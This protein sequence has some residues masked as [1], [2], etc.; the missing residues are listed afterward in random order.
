MSGLCIGILL[1]IGFGCTTGYKIP[2]P[3]VELLETGFSVSIPDEEG[4][5]VVAFNVNRN[6]NFTSFINEGQYNVRLTEPQNGRW[7]TN[8]SSVPLRAQDVLY[9]W[10]SVQHQKAVY[11]DL[12]QPLPVC[13]L[14]GE[15]RPKGCSP[16]DDDFT[17][18]NQLST[19]GSALEPTAPSVCEP[20]ETQVS[21]QIG[22]SICKGQLL[23][24][25][26]FDQLNESLWIHDVRLPLDS[27]DA[28]FVLYDGKAKVHDGNLVIEPLLW[29]SY[30]PDLSIA[31]SRLDLSE[32]CTGT[33]NRNKEC[34]LHSTGSGPSGIMPPIVT[35]RVSTKDTFAF[36]YG[37]IEMRAK[38]PKGDWIVPLLLLEPLTEWYGQSGYESGQLRVALARGNSVLR[39]PRGKLVDGR[40]LYG[41]PVL[42]T[43]AHQR[44]DLWLSKRKISH[45][46]DDFHTYSLDWSSNRLLFSVD[47]QVY[48][49]MLNGFTE[50]DENPRWKQGGPMAPFDKMFYISLG[51]SVG[52]FGDFVDHLR[53]ATYEKPWANYHP[54]AKLQ[55]HQAQDQWLPTW[56]QPA[57]KIDY[58]RVFAN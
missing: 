30:R 11:Q 50:L 6:R 58:V 34:I 55:F 4:V 20:S 15:Y 27:K 32:R 13:N 21:P 43:D 53:T 2:T 29:S 31:N 54:Q 56:K 26:T 47:G 40:S 36:Q 28:E 7:T 41:G 48:G 46:G 22:V 25:E 24:E 44:E 23:F 3:T 10:T 19:E 16:G 39:M 8:F 14:G 5:K 42:S 37:R 33:H 38:L 51:V 9:L 17:D 12:A 52:G 35:P 1:L 57:L 18:D 45:F 49:E